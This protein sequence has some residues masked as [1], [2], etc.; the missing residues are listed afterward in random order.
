MVLSIVVP[1]VRSVDEVSPTVAFRSR[2]ENVPHAH[3]PIVP[4]SPKVNCKK[5][6]SPHAPDVNKVLEKKT[7][8]TNYFLILPNN[9]L[10]GSDT[11]TVLPSTS[12]SLAS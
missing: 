8:S 3:N 11:S 4:P 2:P 12:F 10:D 7:R 9:H 5:K 6:T 1:E